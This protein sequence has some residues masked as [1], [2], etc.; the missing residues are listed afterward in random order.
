MAE[1]LWA[2][3]HVEKDAE[4]A[5]RDAVKVGE[6]EA[7]G[8]AV[9]LLT[10]VL[11]GGVFVAAKA[12]VDELPPWTLVFF[13]VSIA[14]LVL[15]PFV[16]GHRREMATFLKAH[17]LSALVIG[18]LGLGI[19][20]GLMFSALPTTSAVN[21]GII[22]AI[23][24]IIT[25]VLARFFLGEN[26]GPW[27]AVGSAIAFL[28]IVVIAV[29]G[30]LTVLLNLDLDAGDFWVLAAAIIFAGYTIL[31]KRAKFELPRLP[32]LAILLCGGAL[33]ALPLFLFELAD[34]RHQNLALTGYAALAYAAIPGGALMY[35][36]FNWSIDVLGAARAG[37][38]LYSQMIFTAILAWLVL[39]EPIAGY[40]L[41]GAA[42]I[43]VGVILITVLKPKAKPAA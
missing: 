42:L 16:I 8:Y 15:L 43:V 3:A 24:P 34:G 25:L 30:S 10:W 11:A 26:L 6:S 23:S 35:L 14:A 9:G 31:L 19:T 29:D 36:L 28:G 5:K 40:H 17:W 33:S 13:R 7:V 22:F 39:G 12:A 21:A 2:L 37:G 27:Q 1:H 20:Q 18:A 32:L 41:A 4:T 38:L